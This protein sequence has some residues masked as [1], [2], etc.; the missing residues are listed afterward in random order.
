MA[1]WPTKK[2]ERP[3]T[4]KPDFPAPEFP[5]L[6][7]EDA[8]SGKAENPIRSAAREPAVRASNSS[9]ADQLTALTQRLEGLERLLDQAKGELHSYLLQREAQGGGDASAKVAR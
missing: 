3:A 4:A 9:S 1:I 6:G 5:D 2:E 7:I 8:P